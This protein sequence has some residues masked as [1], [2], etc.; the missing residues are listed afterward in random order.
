MIDRVVSF[1]EIQQTFAI[2][3]EWEMVTTKEKTFEYIS[4]LVKSCLLNLSVAQRVVEI[5]FASILNEILPSFGGA[6]ATDE[7]L[8]LHKIEAILLNNGS[9]YYKYWN[10]AKSTYLFNQYASDNHQVTE[11]YFYW[12][13][14]MHFVS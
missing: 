3:K 8:I 13:I 14:S 2:E 11:V 6:L 5:Q 7:E 10:I 9:S 12:W 1:L 4:T